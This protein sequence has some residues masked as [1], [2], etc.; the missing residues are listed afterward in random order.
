MV[1]IANRFT[2]NK[3]KYLTAVQKFRWPFWDYYRPREEVK[4][5]F[6]GIKINPTTGDAGKTGKTTSFPYDFRAPTIFTTEQI[7]L[8]SWP[9]DELAL[10]DNP[11]YMFKQPRKNGIPSSDYDKLG[12]AR[13]VSTY[14]MSR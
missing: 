10:E 11:L 6:P 7:M 8:R 2:T 12:L 13:S 1:E 14:L 3:D 5:V 4:T 9:D